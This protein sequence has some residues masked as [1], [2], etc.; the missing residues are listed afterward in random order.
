MTK[1][2]DIYSQLARYMNIK[3]PNAVYHFDGSGINNPSKYSRSLYS[4]LN[5]RAWPDMFIA[6]TA[7]MPGSTIAYSGLFLEI[8]ADG[9]RVRKRDGTWASD[10]IAEQA[11][12]ADVLQDAGY[13]AVLVTGLDQCVEVIES[14]LAGSLQS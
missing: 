6:A 4:R 8:K 5:G 2:V 13:I 7:L 9:V 11:A 1:E 12:M 10:H 14:Y 3:H